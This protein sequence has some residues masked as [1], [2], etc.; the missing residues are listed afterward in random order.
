[1]ACGIKEFYLFISGRAGSFLLCRLCSSCSER[2]YS[3]AE[4]PRLLMAVASL[5]GEH[6]LYGTGFSSC[7]VWAQ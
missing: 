6:G 1:M 4:E 2:G 5:V 3:L 7:G